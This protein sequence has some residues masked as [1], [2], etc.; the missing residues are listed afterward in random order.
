MQINK[1]ILILIISII[2]N[3]KCFNQQFKIS[4]VPIYFNN[5]SISNNF[6]ATKFGYKPSPTIQNYTSYKENKLKT[7]YPDVYDLRDLGVLTS[8]KD[9]GN[10][11]ACWTFGV[12]GSLES[13]L[14]TKMDSVYNL[15]EENMAT[16]HGFNY[17]KNE[18]GNFNI[19]TSYL[20]NLKGPLL[21]KEDPYISSL[22]SIC[23]IADVK[24]TIHVYDTYW[25]RKEV[26]D[27]KILLMNYGAIPV[28]MF[29]DDPFYNL[30]DNT[31]YYSGSEDVN[32]LVLLTGWD[33]DKEISYFGDRVQKNKKG[34][35]IAKNS[36]G[37]NWGDDGY[38]YISYD[39][40]KFTSDG[41]IIPDIYENNE[42]DTLI[43]Y[44][45]LGYNSSI[46]YYFDKNG[47]NNKLNEGYGVS[48]FIVKGSQQL[49]K[50]GTYALS[51][52]TKITIEIYDAFN[53]KVFSGLLDSISNIVCQYVGYHTFNVNAI[54]NN[55]FY[56]KVKY[57]TP[58]FDYPIP[59]ETEIKDY[60]YPAIENSIS[61]IS[62]DNKY[63]EEIGNNIDEKNFDLCIK[64]YMVNSLP[65]YETLEGDKPITVYPVPVSDI[66][67]YK[68]NII[69]DENI[70]IR[71]F[72]IKGMVIFEKIYN[73][74]KDDYLLNFSV[75]DLPEGMYYLNSTC[76]DFSITSK[77]LKTQ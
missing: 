5:D 70:I 52:G 11:G 30:R 21:E 40:S 2:V 29:Y 33:D 23:K 54:V 51:A 9:Q 47:V 34:A 71:F 20:V 16:C 56:I 66:L 6:S 39:D 46:G 18:G 67:Y 62:P 28:T 26:N 60:A 63:F 44:D 37:R 27:Y 3:L 8:V 35:W 10:I 61:W 15:S 19:A 65:V 64:A 50:V 55:Q 53:G 69:T 1:I 12:I 42:F 59:I 38:F 43:Y 57:E 58:E 31:Y 73:Q 49:K 22:S 74:K 32:H 17:A 77:I 76:N 36:W 68:V 24:P 41:L 13:L 72:D 48:K 75:I 4:Y 25:V 7:N 45:E 14:L